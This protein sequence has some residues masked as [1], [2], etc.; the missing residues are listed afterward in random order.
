MMPAQPLRQVQETP[1]PPRQS[2]CKT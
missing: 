2:S 1:A